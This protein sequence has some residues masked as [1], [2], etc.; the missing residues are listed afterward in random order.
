MPGNFLIYR[1]HR[2]KI[3]KVF[4]NSHEIKKYQTVENLENFCKQKFGKGNYYIEHKTFGQ[5]GNRLLESSFGKDQR[6][7][8]K[9]VS[10]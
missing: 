1:S 3:C 9:I 8:F 10:C 4:L 7:S 2:S 5:F 6:K